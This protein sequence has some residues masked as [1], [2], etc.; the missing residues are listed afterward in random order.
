VR[1]SVSVRSYK[2]SA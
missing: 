1:A 2:R